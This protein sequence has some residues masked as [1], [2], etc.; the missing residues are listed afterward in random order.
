MRTD[1]RDQTFESRPPGRVR[2]NKGRAARYGLDADVITPNRDRREVPL[3]EGLAQWLERLTPIARDLDCSRE[4]EF[5][6]ELAANGASYSRQRAAGGPE[7]A[8]R[9]LLTETGALTPFG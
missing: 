4:L 8:L 9:L 2:E 1:E 5:A 6:A 7:Q 3:R